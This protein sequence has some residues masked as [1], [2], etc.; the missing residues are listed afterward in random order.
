MTVDEVVNRVTE[1][2]LKQEKDAQQAELLRKQRQK[3]TPWGNFDPNRLTQLAQAGIQL[4]FYI[5]PQKD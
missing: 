3:L 2:R 4:S 5:A 1:L